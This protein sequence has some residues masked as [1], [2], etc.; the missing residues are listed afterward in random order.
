MGQFSRAY[1]PVANRLEA[2]GTHKT[3]GANPSMHHLLDMG[4]LL[5]HDRRGIRLP[6]FPSK[7]PK[8]RHAKHTIWTTEVINT[9]PTTLVCSNSIPIPRLRRTTILPRPYSSE[10]CDDIS[11]DK[12]TFMAVPPRNEEKLHGQEPDLPS[13]TS[14][15]QAI[16]KRRLAVNLTQDRDGEETFDTTQSHPFLNATPSSVKE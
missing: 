13:L 4:L 7:T 14:A 6:S 11:E 15:H 5:R 12:P 10:F 9:V 1:S 2:Q 3:V 16:G 8:P